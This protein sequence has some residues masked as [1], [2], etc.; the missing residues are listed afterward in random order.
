MAFSPNL[1]L[2][3]IKGKDGLAR[4]CR[5]EVIIPIPAYIGQSIG[6]SFLEKVLNFPNSIFSDVSDAINSSLGF[7]NE[8]T[9]S[10][11]PSVS[12]YLALQCESAELPGRTLETAD[13]RIYGPSFKVP[14]RMQYTD[15]NLTFLCT[16]EFYERKLFERWMDSIIPSDT[17]NARFPKSNATRYLTNIRIIQYDD[18][19]RQIYAVELMDAFPVGIAPQP[20]SWAE[21]GFHRLS[22]S[23]SYQKYRT[24]FEGQ[25]DI[26]QTL[27]T[28]GG[29]AASR[30]FSF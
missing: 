24:I 30:I 15:T 29:T 6:N 9:R 18:F 1:F 12:R 4:P 8:G 23:F 14:Y 20:L 10:S 7:Q 27:S 11:N 13:A 25:Y 28:L 2:S 26:G 22:V 19:V 17:N 3:N 21:E 5:Y 16:N